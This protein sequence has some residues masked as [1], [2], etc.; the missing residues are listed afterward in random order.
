MKLVPV[1][2]AAA[3]LAAGCGADDVSPEAIADAAEKTLRTKGMALTMEGSVEVPQLS[4]PLRFAGDGEMSTAGRVARLEVEFDDPPADALGSIDADDL[5]FEVVTRDLV[6][7][8]R[9]PLIEDAEELDNKEWL[10]LDLRRA[11]RQAG[12]DLGSFG[13]LGQ[14]DPAQTLR[15]MRAVGE[16]VEEVGE[17]EVGGVE[18][19]HYKAVID[20]RRYDDSV[21]AR[22]RAAAQESVRRLI[23]LGGATFPVEVWIDDQGLVRRDRYTQSLGPAGSEAVYQ[24]EYHDFGR[25]VEIDVPDEDEAFDLTELTGRELRRQTAP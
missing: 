13:Q 20:L 23:R 14:N 5:R 19:T 15:F 16:E 24:T 8:M 7:Y 21:P 10:K 25:S 4:E 3:V 17:E 1:L 11:S 9:T 18:T 12:I 2:M 22:D 6:M